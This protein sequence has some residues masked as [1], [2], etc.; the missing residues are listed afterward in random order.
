MLLAMA[1]KKQEP[2]FEDALKMLEKI[3]DEIE[4]AEIGLEESIEKY[5]QGMKLVT[6][7]REI[8]TQAEQRIQ[9]ITPTPSGE[10]KAEDTDMQNHA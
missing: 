10:L 9:K 8:L 4:H 2:N 1:E 3:T 7:C 6:R 5:E